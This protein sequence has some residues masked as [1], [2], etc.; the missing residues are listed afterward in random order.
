MF[1][2]LDIVFSGEVPP[3]PSE[4]LGSERMKNFLEEMSKQ[5][6][7]ILVDTPPVSIVSDACIVA[8]FLDG[9]LLLARQGRTRKDAVRRAVNQLDLTGTKLLGFVLNG[10]DKSERGSYGYYYYEYSSRDTKK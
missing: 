8:N 2:N 7:Y 5:Y 9:A 4:L 1:P 3:N 6:D 10:V